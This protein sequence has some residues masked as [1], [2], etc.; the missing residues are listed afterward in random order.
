MRRKADKS[1][2][3]QLERHPF[4]ALLAFTILVGGTVF[5]VVHYFDSQRLEATKH[6]YDLKLTDSENKLASINRGLAGGDYINVARL[7]VHRGERNRVPLQ[8]KF[9]ADDSFYAPDLRAWIY[10]KTTDR[11]FFTSIFGEEGKKQIN[12]LTGLAPVHVWTRGA[13][14]PVGNHDVIQNFAP[15]IYLQ[16]L[17][18]DELTVQ[19]NLEA[20]KNSQPAALFQGDIIGAML[21]Q[22]FANVFKTLTF[23]SDTQASLLSITKVSN[24]LYCQFLL[25]IRNVTVDSRKLDSYFVNLEMIVISTNNNVYT[26]CDIIPSEEPILR[27][28]ISAE[29]TEWLNAFAVYSD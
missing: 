13:L 9:Y 29:V 3:A 26:I 19:L 21:A 27:G 10:K 18:I 15:C 22:T 6:D 4:R 14:V 16:R 8:S 23:T 17:P 24:V 11:E 2:W 25:T 12:E 1:A 20:A 7:V 28:P 5:S